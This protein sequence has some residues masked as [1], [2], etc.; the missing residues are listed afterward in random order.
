MRFLT[1]LVKKNKCGWRGLSLK[2]RTPF[3]EQ[4]E[5]DVEFKVLLHLFLN[6]YVHLPLSLLE[7]GTVFEEQSMGFYLFFYPKSCTSPKQVQFHCFAKGDDGLIPTLR[8]IKSAVV[9]LSYGSLPPSL[10]L[11]LLLCGY[12]SVTILLQ[13]RFFSI[14][15]LRFHSQRL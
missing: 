9:T 5:A 13:Q 2:S 10:P 6:V 12:I 4:C 14:S 3:I 15:T 8:R 7:K 11:L 1:L